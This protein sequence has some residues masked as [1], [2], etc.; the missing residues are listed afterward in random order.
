M[1]SNKNIIKSIISISIIL[2]ILLG[3]DYLIITSDELSAA[4]YKISDIYNNNEKNYFLDTEVVLIGDIDTDINTFISNKINSYENLRYLLLIGD[5]NN[6]PYLYKSITQQEYSGCEEDQE[7][8]YPTDDL[9]S[10]ISEDE[11]PRLATGR[12]PAA[13]IEQALSYANKLENYLDDQID[14]I[15]KNKIILVSDDEIKS[16]SEI[17]KEIEH[18]QIS[19]S[20]YTLLSEMTFMKTLYGPMYEATYNGSYRTLPELTHDIITNLNEGA[21]L[22]NYI[23]HG[24]TQKW[25]AEHI[26]EKDRDVPNIN[27]ENNKL[28]IWM[29][30]T[31]YFGRYDD[32]ESISESLLFDTNAAISIIGATRAIRIDINENFVYNFYNE[33]KNYI[34]NS[35]NKSRLG[36]LFLEA[37]NQLSPSQYLGSSTCPDNGGYL[38]DILGDPALPLP[39]AKIQQNT[40][41]FPNQ[42]DLLSTIEINSISNNNYEFMQVYSSNNEMTITF[43]ENDENINL[44]FSLPNIIYQNTFSENSCY[45]PPIDLMSYENIKIRYYTEGNEQNFISYS[46][47]IDINQLTNENYNLINDF[48][49]PEISFW[50]ND[51]ELLDNSYIT[52]NNTID[53]FILDPLD[54]NTSNGIGHSTKFWFNDNIDLI[55]NPELIHLESCNGIS[56]STE[57][58]LEKNNILYVEAWD[59][60]NN[61]TLDSLVINVKTESSNEKIFNVYN[62]PN[63]FFDR[64]F[65]TYQIKDIPNTQINTELTIYTQ[66][67]IAINTIKDTQQTNNFISIEWD[68]KDYKSNLIPSGTYIYTLDIKFNNKSYNK[69]N[70]LSIIR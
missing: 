57:I 10:S 6:F 58:D 44:S 35:S 62:F 1:E 29:A 21:A 55:Y 33:I 19:D 40:I 2:N 25:A 64:T 69:R 34:E 50:M 48:T 45:T 49:G 67:G 66:D 68:G 53:I 63:P 28:P 47:Q 22:I 9:Y 31:C 54:I 17:Q 46:N 42:I 41:V 11:K 4:A 14:G 23:G 51:I 37:K 16:G 5:E 7:T 60:A 8:Q 65:F 59:S 70:V 18:T 24:D 61:K 38:F 12:I 3:K 30:G 32:T 43:E 20:L 36:D 39:F 56:F 15:W 13:N 26:I 27:I 52:S